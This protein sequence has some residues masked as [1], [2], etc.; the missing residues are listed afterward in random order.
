[1]AACGSMLLHVDLADR[2]EPCI[3]DRF[4][5]S[6]APTWD[7]RCTSLSYSIADCL[8]RARI[9][10]DFCDFCDFLPLYIYIYIYFCNMFDIFLTCFYIFLT[11]F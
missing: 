7:V 6:S 10:C 2:A 11:Y 5:E 9:F 8:F 3:F 4:W 1:M